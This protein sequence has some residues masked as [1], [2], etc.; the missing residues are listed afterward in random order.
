MGND[1]KDRGLGGG[2]FCWVEV[3]GSFLDWNIGEFFLFRF[4]LED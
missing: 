1:V 2:G 3:K 4:F